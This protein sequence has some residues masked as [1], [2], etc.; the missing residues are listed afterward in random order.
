MAED[1]DHVISS[2]D[3]Y[4]AGIFNELSINQG[5]IHEN[6]EFLIFWSSFH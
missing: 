1:Y 3:L 2:N 4:S 5:R 6:F